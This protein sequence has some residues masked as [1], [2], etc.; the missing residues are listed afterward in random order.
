[1]A[2]FDV[3]LVELGKL[4]GLFA[5]TGDSQG[6]LRWEWFGRPIEEGLET[7][8]AQRDRIGAILRALLRPEAQAAGAFNGPAADPA[9]NWE[10]L[11][12]VDAI[13]GGL[14]ITWSKPDDTALVIGIGAKATDIGGEPVTLAVLAKMLEIA[15]GSARHTLGNVE[16]EGTFP[17]PEFL[18]SGALDGQVTAVPDTSVSVGLTAA[19][20]GESRTLAYQT[21]GPAAALE[22]LGWD[23]T[24]LAVFVLKAFIAGRDEEIF[25]RV[26][27]HLFPMLGDPPGVIQSLPIVDEMGQ[28]ADFDPWGQSLSPVPNADGALTFLWHL[29]ALLTGNE[30]PSFFTGS[31]YFPLV[32]PAPG[33]QPG[34]APT[35]ADSA[36]QRPADPGPSAWVAV[37]TEPSAYTLAIEL[38]NAGGDSVQIP[39]AHWDGQSLS[40]PVFDP[41]AGIDL[42]MFGG[43]Q[44][45]VTD[46]GV[47]LLEQ[48]VSDG[49]AELQGDYSLALQFTANQ[50]PTIALQTPLIDI[51]FPP[52]PDQAPALAAAFISTVIQIA[53]SGTDFEPVLSALADCAGAAIRGEAPDIADGLALLAALIAVASEDDGTEIAVELDDGF[54]LTLGLPANNQV[55]LGA[56]FGPVDSGGEDPDLV[57]GKINAGLTLSLG[58]AHVLDGFLLGFEDLRPGDTGAAGGIVADLIPDLREMPGFDFTFGYS[59]AQGITVAGGGKIPI[60]RTI[61]PV[62]IAALLVELRK[63]SVAI[64]LDLGFELGPILVAAYELGLEIDF[65]N[66]LVTPF[67]HG[68]GL[69]MDTDAIKLGGFFAAVDSVVEGDT[70]TD[71]VGG[72]VVSV[73]GYFELSAIGGYTQV[74]DDPSLFIF[75][76]LVAPLGGP[77]WF[78]MTGVAGG[79]G[80]NRALPNPELML[81]HPFMKVMRGELALSDDAASALKTLSDDFAPEPGQFW[82]AAGIQFV[83]FGFITGR[84]VVAISFG[85]KFS[86]TILGMASFSLEPLAYIEIGILTTV[87]EEKFVLRASLSPNSYI[88]H[89]DIFS[90]QGDIA[91]CAWYAPPHKGDFLFSIGGYHPAFKKPEHY[92]ELVRVGAKATLYGFL[93]LSVEVFFA[94]TPQALMAGAKAALW[95]EFMGIAAGCEVYVDVLITWDPFFL[96]AGIGVVLW[97]EF[98]GRHEIGVHLDIYTPEFGGTATIDLAIVSFEVSFGAEIAAPPAPRIHEFMTNQLA[99][100]AKEKAGGARVPAFNTADTTGLLR[101]EFLSG[102][103]GTGAPAE[104]EQ[105]EGTDPSAPVHLGPEWSFLLRT[106][107]PIDPSAV[108]AEGTD[109]PAAVA[110][111]VNLPLCRKLGL[112]SD[113]A[114]VSPT[115]DAAVGSG[116]V[117]REW[118]TEFHPAATF[119]PEYLNTAQT[120]DGA[121]A[122]LDSGSPSVPLVEGMVVHCGPQIATPP[123]PLAATEAEDPD[124]DEVYPLPL[125]DEA[126]G[127]LSSI[128]EQFAFAENSA[129]VHTVM[130]SGKARRDVAFSALRGRARAPLT[131]LVR[132][133]A[134]QNSVKQSAG[135]RF[136][137]AGPAA[138]GLP[139]MGPPASPARLPEL[140]AVTLK[141]LRPRSDHAGPIRKLETVTRPVQRTVTSLSEAGG[142]RDGLSATVEV[143]SGRAQLIEFGGGGVSEL[144]LQ[145]NGDQH[146][147][148]VAFDRS[149]DVILDRHARG[150]GTVKLPRGTARTL[151]LGAGPAAA[152]M[153]AGVTRDTTLLA[154]DAR[155]FVAPGA[156]VTSRTPM[157]SEIH[158]LDALPGAELFAA[159]RC[160][161]IRFG[162]T[163]RAAVL[164]LRV[165]PEVTEPGPAEEQV[166]W[167][168]VGAHLRDL[169]PV[170]GPDLV[171]LTMAV[172]ADSGWRLEVDLGPEWRLDGVAVLPGS[173]KQTVTQ[174]RSG[175]Q[176]ELVDDAIAPIGA[177]VTKV[178]VEARV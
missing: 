154:V 112:A 75:A 22:I 52:T 74:G 12:E 137:L 54:E 164:V 33:G 48:N 44:L 133:A 62:E 79:F 170:I 121:A 35:S 15:G 168:A 167:R 158:A 117:R 152:R 2:S 67:L 145:M 82:V 78:F 144:A 134:L 55:A 161:D 122:D 99:L 34:S 28:S 5:A 27:A 97:F 120:G 155:S 130:P 138:A 26:S 51:A 53:S 38:W 102:R 140:Q 7:M 125:G 147:R 61:G 80:F 171:T 45:D 94:C 110:G 142:V 8:P 106:R 98:F 162:A 111:E 95:G 66:G 69:A 43:G 88:L 146:V 128:I 90:L 175:Q 21:P 47:V 17:V 24:R 58:T 96:R 123:V 25:Q 18:E 77:P 176:M 65:Q 114:I 37:L 169:V 116:A 166:R 87:D 40:G 85:H 41:P 16:F 70:V 89:P 131:A 157:R 14:G 13:S 39:L 153:S 159:S 93:N 135:R 20:N 50:P 151:L 73:A 126:P 119:G 56:A 36:G 84:V 173:V 76:S 139:R 71:Y 160:L 177:A 108:P 100:P 118:I 23:A 104:A 143:A 165:V 57:I 91:L 68:L 127:P 86:F 64:G 3:A 29:R 103:V 32:T 109:H 156:V 59:E 132:G 107:L 9:N 101:I 178:N 141:V 42:T 10:P 172:A 1:M 136:G 115:L 60:Q 11:L 83:S 113:L 129:L 4:I 92:P 31:F 150:A 63:E 30:D 149:G 49:P 81:D 6:S 163:P 124:T 46:A 72:A 174:A 105:Q 19:A 148:T